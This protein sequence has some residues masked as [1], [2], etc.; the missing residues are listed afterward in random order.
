MTRRRLD[1]LL[2]QI[3]SMDANMCD[4]W[5]HIRAGI[6]VRLQI[7]TNRCLI[8]TI[9]NVPVIILASIELLRCAQWQCDLFQ[10]ASDWIRRRTSIWIRINIRQIAS[11]SAHKPWI[12]KC[13]QAATST[14]LPRLAHVSSSRSLRKCC[15]IIF[16]TW[17][18]DAWTTPS[19]I[20][21]FRLFVLT[22][23]RRNWLKILFECWGF[24][25]SICS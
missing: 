11:K 6:A 4:N 19:P 7:R 13:P 2:V 8:S 3:A 12:N 1:S 15:F 10:S 23:A 16:T 20:D 5:K 9:D 14:S 18:V 17:R 24:N 22:L 21:T 25:V